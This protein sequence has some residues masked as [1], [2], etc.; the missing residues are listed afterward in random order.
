MK[1]VIILFV[2]AAATAA[3]H[4]QVNVSMGSMSMSI[5]P[6]SVMAL[7]GTLTMSHAANRIHASGTLQV[8]NPSP[9]AISALANNGI[10]CENTASTGGLRWNIKQASTYTFPLINLNGEAVPFIVTPSAADANDRYLRVSSYATNAANEPYPSN[11]TDVNHLGGANHSAGMPD[12]FWRVAFSSPTSVEVRFN[13]APSEDAANGTAGM[14]MQ[15]WVPLGW[16]N[17]YG[18]QTQSGTREVQLN[19]FTFGLGGD[20]IFSLQRD[21]VA[22]NMKTLLDGPY[23]AN[24]G[25]MNDGLRAASLIPLM[26]PYTGLGYNMQG[27]GYLSTNAGFMNTTGNDALV[28]WVLLELRSAAN[29]SQVVAT[30]PA[31]IQRDGD[32]V[33]RFLAPQNYFSVPPGDYFVALRH[34]NHLGVMTASPIA[35]SAS[36]SLVDFRSSAQATYGSSARKS[37]GAVMTLWS[38]NVDADGTLKYVGPGN[39]RDPILM[40]IGGNVPTNTLAGYV[41]ADV[42]MDGL[43]KYVGNGN[44]RDPILSNIGGSV[45]TNVRLEQLP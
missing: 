21:P 13:Y 29:S 37:Q 26:E 35:L 45:P 34:R 7:P 33:G 5:K 24:S 27:G 18:A 36:A 9:T 12:R 8:S 39:D 3:A 20:M 17:G 42:N 19:T 32:V 4:A 43:V 44:D 11:V 15:Y 41:Q 16:Q 1:R 2:A 38:G 40:A 14:R 30:M 10:V 25:L 23:D 31:L 28:D 22:F 6:S